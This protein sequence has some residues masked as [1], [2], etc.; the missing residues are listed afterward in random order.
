MK[1]E[2]DKIKNELAPSFKVWTD[3]ER[4]ARKEMIQDIKNNLS[5]ADVAAR[6]YGLNFVSHRKG[7][8][9]IKAVEHSSMVFDLKNN[10]VYWNSHGNHAMNAIDFIMTYEDINGE[11]AIQ[12]AIEFNEKKDLRSMDQFIY[13]E[14]EDRSYTV[15]GL[16]M[17]QEYSNNDKAID[18]LTNQRCID[19]GI[20]N[21][22]IEKGMLYES[23]DYHN[24]V[25]I[26]YD[27]NKNP[28]FGMMRGTGES[29]FRIDLTGSYKANGFYIDNDSDALVVC[30]SVIDGLSYLTL[31]PEE[32]VNV[33]CASGAGCLETT[34]LNN[35][36]KRDLIKKTNK[37]ICATDHDDAGNCSRRGINKW[38]KEHNALSDHKLVFQDADFEG[39]DVN[40]CLVSRK[41]ETNQLLNSR[42]EEYEAGEDID[43]EQSR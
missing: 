8:R 35:L 40:E 21:D 25:F 2:N 36:V 6:L 15:K 4:K 16:Q 27:E 38:V 18:Y 9:Y 23:N 32:K 33:L 17:P 41:V 14:K 3:D 1:T 29:K 12:K 19:N 39:K 42:G 30:E 10:V 13:D 26:G 24:C 22:L 37:I 20:V 11:E 28:A 34:L 43:E 7:Q 31:H 5:V